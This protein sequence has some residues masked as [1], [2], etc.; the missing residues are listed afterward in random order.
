MDRT[1]S[2][3]LETRLAQQEQAIDE[4]SNELYQQQKQIAQLEAAV[5]SL[6]EG[7]RR[8]DS[9]ESQGTDPADEVPPHY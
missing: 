4:L 3:E 1:T 8:I 6:T 2:A 9:E 5:R 7:L